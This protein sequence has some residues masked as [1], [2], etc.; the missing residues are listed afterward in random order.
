MLCGEI[1]VECVQFTLGLSDSLIGDIPVHLL[2]DQLLNAI[3]KLNHAPNTLY[4]RGVKFGLYHATVFTVINLSVNHGIAVILY[5]RVGRDGSVD[6][7]AVAKVGQLRFCVT[8]FN[9][10]NS[11]FELYTEVKVFIRSNRKILSAVLRT[12]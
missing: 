12:L 2:T 9:V 6:C 5:I 3:T 4:C 10:L 7:F 11:I 1:V 8:A